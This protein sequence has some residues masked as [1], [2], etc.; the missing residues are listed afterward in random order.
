MD[1]FLLL[2]F[3]QNITSCG[4]LIEQKKSPAQFFPKLRGAFCL[5]MVRLS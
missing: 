3:I 5:L 1:W 2:D 4:E